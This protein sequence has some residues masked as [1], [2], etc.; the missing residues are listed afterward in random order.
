MNYITQCRP[1]RAQRHFCA[2]LSCGIFLSSRI[3]PGLD[4]I[5]PA[6]AKGVAQK[7]KWLVLGHRCISKRKVFFGIPDARPA[8][9]PYRNPSRGK[10]IWQ[11]TNTMV[12]YA[13][14]WYLM[15]LSIRHDFSYWWTLALSVVAAGF[16]VRLFIFLITVYP[17][18]T[19][20]CLPC[21]PENL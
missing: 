10:A 20:R 6:G 21:G 17:S 9:S 1:A 3:F 18:V 4:R 14:L 2:G 16:L 8:L 15:I 13:G 5:C 11:I 7:L 12:P 19:T